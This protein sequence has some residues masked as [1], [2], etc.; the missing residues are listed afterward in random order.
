M[1]FSTCPTDQKF[2]N[3]PQYSE[4]ELCTLCGC[5]EQVEETHTGIMLCEK[6]I[7]KLGDFVKHVEAV[8]NDEEATDEVYVFEN[9]YCVFGEFNFVEF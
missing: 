5:G 2:A 3:D 1:T 9:G 6:C 7:D 4:D 8:D